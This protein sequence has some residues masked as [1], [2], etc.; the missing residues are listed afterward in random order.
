[1]DFINRIEK[2]WLRPGILVGENLPGEYSLDEIP[3]NQKLV[4]S[5]ILNHS[6]QQEIARLEQPARW[7]TTLFVSSTRRAPMLF[8]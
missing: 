5:K 8:E 7:E 6:Q 1:M 2:N 4:L 3:E